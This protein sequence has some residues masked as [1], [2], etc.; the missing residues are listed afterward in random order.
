[1]MG[2][3]PKLPE[4]RMIQRSIRMP[5]ALWEKIDRMGMDRLRQLIKRA[6]ETQN[7]N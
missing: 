7:K 3:P 1:M 2:R 4:E 5:P 6:R